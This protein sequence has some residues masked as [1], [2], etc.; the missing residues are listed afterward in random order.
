MKTISYIFTY[1]YSA[2][3][4]EE[5]GTLNRELLLFNEIAREENY[6]F[7]LILMEQRD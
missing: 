4:W 6:K 3:T 5:S 1:D 7:K 2:A